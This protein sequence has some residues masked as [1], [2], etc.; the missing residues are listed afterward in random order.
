MDIPSSGWKSVLLRVKDE[1]GRD[2]LSVVSAGVAF[3]A[4]LALPPM[5]VAIVSI[6]GLIS[7]PADVQAQIQSVASGAPQSVQQVLSQQLNRIVGTSSTSLGLS[8]VLSL[9]FAIWSAKKGMTSLLKAVNIAYDQREKR[10]FFKFNGLALLL[11]AGAI[12]LA[13]VAIALVAILPAVLGTLGLGGVASAL[14]AIVRWPLLAA[15]VIVALAV[16]YRY[17]PSQPKRPWRWVTP[18]SVL[19]TALWLIVS[20]VFSYY[21]SNFGNYNETY[22]SLGA[23]IVTLLWLFLTAF[24]VLIGAELNA[25]LEGEAREH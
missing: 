2:N 11:T 24:S 21:V 10:G 8:L 25:E 13:V 17:G 22:G 4:L 19:A 20:G 3:Y 9:L 7:N 15:V 6:Y 14:V 18:G 12:V 23:V 5:L 16:I 1:I